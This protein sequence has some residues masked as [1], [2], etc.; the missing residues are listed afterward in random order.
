MGTARS[1]ELLRE[2]GHQRHVARPR[3]RPG[4]PLAGGPGV[5]L[6]PPLRVEHPG[7]AP[8][9]VPLRGL[10]V[11]AV[12][13]EQLG[14]GG[15]LRELLDALLGVD[16]GVGG[17]HAGHCTELALLL[18]ARATADAARRCEALPMSTPALPVK[19]REELMA[20]CAYP[21]RRRHQEAH[22]LSL[23]DA[24]RPSSRRVG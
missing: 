3:V 21:R 14:V 12:E 9:H 6:G 13:V 17:W 18:S 5:E 11:E 22:G 1:A 23:A 7:P 16:E 15:A 8:L 19:G 10:L 2:L 4:H 24:S 20:E